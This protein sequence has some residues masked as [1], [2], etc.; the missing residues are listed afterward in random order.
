MVEIARLP[1]DCNGVLI[2]QNNK[3]VL[4]PTD[5][6]YIADYFT[7]KISYYHRTLNSLSTLANGEWGQIYVL[8]EES[9]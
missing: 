8:I 4:Y 3:C 6:T 7:K 1:L 9:S 2:A 5:A